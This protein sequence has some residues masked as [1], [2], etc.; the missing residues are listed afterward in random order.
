[1]YTNIFNI[2]YYNR[3]HFLMV[4]YLESSRINYRFICI[5]ILYLIKKLFISGEP[6]YLS[7]ILSEKRT[8]YSL[9]IIQ[10]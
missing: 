2:P 6:F 10:L 9:P 5:Y 3:F 8:G 1:M 7:N 4:N